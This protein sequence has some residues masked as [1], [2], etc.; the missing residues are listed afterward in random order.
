MKLRPSLLACALSALCSLPAAATDLS[1][2]GFGTLGYAQ[3]NRDYTYQRFISDTGT[4]ERDSLLGG[5]LDAQF[6]PQW[7]ATVQLTLAPSSKRDGAWS[8]TPSWAFVGWRPADDWLVR[9]GRLRVP[10]Y[11][12]SESLDVGDSHDMAR[13]P[14]EM[15]SITPTNDFNGVTLSKSWPAG[16][17]GELSADLYHGTADPYARFWFRDGAPPYVAAGANFSQIKLRVT[18]LVFTLRQPDLLLRVGL[19]HAQTRRADGSE[20]PADFP[21][22]EAFPGS[23][24]GYYQVSNAFP[25]PGVVSVPSIDNYL[26]T[27]GAEYDFGEGWRVAG[28]FARNVQR[29]TSFGAD[30]RGG[31]LAVFKR[32]ADFTPYVSVSA[33]RSSAASLDWY[34]RLTTPVPLPGAEAIS[35]AQRMAAESTYTADQHSL[36]VG[37]AYRINPTSKL[38]LEWMRT[39]IGRV[40]R[41][42][43][44]PAGSASPRDTNVDVI[45]INYN[46]VF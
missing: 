43:D 34:D 40:T 15:Y 29:K 22:V 46:F 27:V 36:A 24:L 4:F 6:S 30:T 17:D 28:E 19:H 12:H 3:S 32:V 8:L 37:T 21:F 42:V 5:Q 9:V 33:L 35:A 26:G 39:H 14:T 44:T 7:S 11:L 10:L 25:G 31:Y 2:S 20:L 16:L 41:L 38:K 23:G 45:S 18:G 1:W 13:L